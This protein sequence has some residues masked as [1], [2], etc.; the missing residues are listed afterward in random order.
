[1]ISFHKNY[2]LLFMILLVVEIFIA[3]FV[4]DK[5][6]RPYLGDFL[7]VILVYVFF[8]SFTDCSVYAAAIF[9]LLFAYFLEILQFFQIIKNL[10]LEEYRIL[11]I[12]I[13]NHFEW[14]DMIAYTLG[15]ITV[16]AAEA[17]WRRK[18]FPFAS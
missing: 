10:G 15:I 6:V 12:I 11:S 3:V 1:M 13:G 9:S 18:N 14:S 17:Y 4:Q 8:K 2:F 5:F 7:A 16:I